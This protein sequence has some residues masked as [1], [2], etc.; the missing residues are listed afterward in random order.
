MVSAYFLATA[1]DT[2]VKDAATA[3][4]ILREGTWHAWARTNT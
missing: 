4:N 2:P 3:F 1:V